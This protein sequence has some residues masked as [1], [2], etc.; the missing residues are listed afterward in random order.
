MSLVPTDTSMTP[1]KL[2]DTQGTTLHAVRTLLRPASNT[3]VR[4]IGTERV[5]GA[6]PQTINVGG[7]IRTSIPPPTE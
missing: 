7:G 3:P 4:D 6:K 1:P 5:Q 2:R